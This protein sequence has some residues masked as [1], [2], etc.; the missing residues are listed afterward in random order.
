MSPEKI[1][2]FWLDDIGSKHWYKSSKNLD[3][4]IFK[5]F[6]SVWVSIMDG[7]CGMWLTFPSGSLAY[8]LVLDQFSRNMF[9]DSPKAFSSDYVALSAAK[10]A[11]KHK[12]DLAIDGPARQFFYLPLMHSESLQDQER[13]IRLL[14]ERMPVGCIDNLLHAKAHREVIRKFGRFP[15]RNEALNRTN[16]S[17]ENVFMQSGGYG[18]TYTQLAN[19]A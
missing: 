18:M 3:T 10:Q 13:C 9:R 11:I 2:K 7:K 17:L 19:N 16:T 14:H 6:Y 4:T 12:F 5:Q 8:I 15:A 1:L